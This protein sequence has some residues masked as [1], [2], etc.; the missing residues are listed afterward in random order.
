MTIELGSLP[1]VRMV[2]RYSIKRLC[3]LWC[4]IQLFA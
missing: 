3:K 1:P 2:C 4:W